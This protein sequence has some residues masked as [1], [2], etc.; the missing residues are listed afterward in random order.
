MIRTRLD[1]NNYGNSIATT[2]DNG[3]LMDALNGAFDSVYTLSP[4]TVFNF[5]VGVVYS[6]DEYD[7]EWAK[8]GESG[9]AKYWPNNPWY[10]P[11]LADMPAVYYPNLNIGVATFVKSC[12]VSYR[13]RKDSCQGSLGR[14]RVLPFMQFVMADRR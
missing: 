14:D 5:R 10:K 3:G 2:S 6:E 8:L 11:Y 13:L 1:N 7:S 12:W 4:R 9:L